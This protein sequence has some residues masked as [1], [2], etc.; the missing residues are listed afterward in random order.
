MRTPKYIQAFNI[1]K[2]E[3]SQSSSVEE[4]A[5][6]LER[7]MKIGHTAV[8][9]YLKQLEMQGVVALERIGVGQYIHSARI[10]KNLDPDRH[11]I[12]VSERLKKALWECRRMSKIGQGWIVHHDDFNLVQRKADLRVGAQFYVL[13]HSL[14][15]DGLIR[16][17]R[18][19]NNKRIFYIVLTE[20]FPAF[21]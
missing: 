18:K 7:R 21:S 16:C 11:E 4:P 15:E 12:E 17:V 19:V 1:L 8:L 3:V 9:Q 2:G 5:R 10:I 6:V 13:L 20:K 14:E